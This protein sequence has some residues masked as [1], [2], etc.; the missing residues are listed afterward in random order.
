MKRRGGDRQALRTSQWR[1]SGASKGRVQPPSR[2]R[3][4]RSPAAVGAVTQL[5]AG[6]EHR[7]GGGSR[8]RTSPP[9]MRRPHSRRPRR[10]SLRLCEE[11]ALSARRRSDWV[12]ALL[13]VGGASADNVRG[14]GRGLLARIGRAGR[15]F[16]VSGAR[17]GLVTVPSEAA[18][19]KLG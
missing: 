16:I 5:T 18:E 19:A 12:H 1:R 3:S 13:R 17:L 15:G 10:L 4:P 14:A 2:L 8:E 6:T 11:A 9:R 7:G